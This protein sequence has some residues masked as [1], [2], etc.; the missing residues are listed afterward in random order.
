MET[1]KKE[2]NPMFRFKIDIAKRKK[3]EGTEIFKGENLENHIPPDKHEKKLDYAIGRWRQALK[4][5]LEIGSTPAFQEPQ[6]QEQLDE[7]KV[8]L[9]LNLS[10]AYLKWDRA[11]EVLPD[12]VTCCGNVLALQP[13][14][15][16]AFYR[17][18]QA[19]EALEDLESAK[20]DLLEAKSLEPN[21]A[22]I[23][24]SFERVEARI[25]KGE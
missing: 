12:V 13:K 4:M 1:D 16:K 25:A 3:E 22:A 7:L 19:H 6:Y 18:A 21:D 17:R 9:N 10:M 5:V 14:N 24:K 20:K 15:V 2:N 11:A 23:K 8:A